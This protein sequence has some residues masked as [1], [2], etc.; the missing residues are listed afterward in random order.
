MSTT[1]TR[2]RARQLSASAAVA[3][4]TLTG[5]GD[6]DGAPAA[7]S[8]PAA[9]GAAAEAGLADFTGGTLYDAVTYARD[10]DL[11]YTVQDPSGNVAEIED[12][13]AYT[14]VEQEPSSGTE[15][16]PR[17]ALELVVEPAE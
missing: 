5:C 1:T 16:E 6:D 9:S 15:F 7:P 3:L 13:R 11:S 12:T 4:L 8:A 10:N 2:R 14:V 17:D